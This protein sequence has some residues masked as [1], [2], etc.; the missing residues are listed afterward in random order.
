M[1]F[2]RSRPSWASWG[3]PTPA[4]R[5]TS[6]SRTLRSSRTCYTLLTSGPSWHN[7]SKCALSS[8]RSSE[9][10]PVKLWCWLGLSQETSSLVRVPTTLPLP[11][12]GSAQHFPCLFLVFSCLAMSTQCWAPASPTYST[13]RMSA[14][15]SQ[16]ASSSWRR[17]RNL[18]LVLKI[19]KS[20]MIMLVIEQP[21]LHQVCWKILLSCQKLKGKYIQR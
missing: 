14:T 12:V 3:K 17:F 21:W 4:S 20:L 11:E 18:D 16:E 6:L 9:V 19:Y 8:T 2:P 1:S 15:Y 7:A 5:S 10:R 13:G